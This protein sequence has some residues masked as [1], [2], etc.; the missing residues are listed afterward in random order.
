M[1]KHLMERAGSSRRTLAAPLDTGPDKTCLRLRFTRLLI[2]PAYTMYGRHVEF[3]TASVCS[4]IEASE[5]AAWGVTAWG[6]KYYGNEV[7]HCPN[8]QAPLI[9]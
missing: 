4:S 5:V 3:G 1:R 7:G 9:N 6:V 2:H 8:N